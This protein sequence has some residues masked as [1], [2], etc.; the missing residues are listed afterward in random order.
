[1]TM[2]DTYTPYIDQL[3]Q[4]LSQCTVTNGLDTEINSTDAFS[5]VQCLLEQIKQSNKKILVIGNGGSAA[6][7]SHIQ[8]D[9]CKATGIRSMVL[10]ETSLLT[11]LTNDD[12]YETAYQQQVQLW[13]EPGDMLIAISS[14]GQ[15]ENILRA[16]AVA[17]NHG[18][19]ILTM[20]GF[21]PTNTLRQLGDL[22]FYIDSDS[23]GMV[24]LSH[25]I[26]GHYLTDQAAGLL[27]AE[28][29][30]T[31]TPGRSR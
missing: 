2:P 20:S 25:S 13:A 6:I 24:E 14:S 11:A 10:T 28:C 17:Q 15:S 1:M 21:S 4:Q 7:A 30:E 12:G 26:I 29:L 27:P 19:F 23:Y 9:L 22:N 31:A 3:H 18:V 5:E 8:N 16:C